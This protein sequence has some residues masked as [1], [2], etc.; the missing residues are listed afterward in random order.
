MPKLTKA[1]REALRAA[2]TETTGPTADYHPGIV[3]EFTDA[4]GE[5]MVEL[6]DGNIEPAT[7]WV[8]DESTDYPTDAWSSESIQRETVEEALENDRC[9]ICGSVD[10]FREDHPADEPE[11]YVPPRISLP[12]IDRS[13]KPVRH[14]TG[15]K[16]ALYVSGFC[17]EEHRLQSGQLT[18]A[19]PEE[20]ANRLHG[21]CPGGT[22][23][24]AGVI[25]I[26]GCPG[27]DGEN[28]C[29]ICRTVNDPESFDSERR[30]CLDVEACED[31]LN[32]RAAQAA[33]TPLARMIREVKEV[34][35]QARRE[36]SVP[37][38][39]RSDS[40][41]GTMPARR[42]SAKPD[43][44]PRPCQCGCALLT[45]GGLFRPGHDAKLK[46]A[47]KRAA[48]DAL[49][50]LEEAEHAMTELAA[51]GWPTPIAPAAQPI[52]EFL[53]SEEM[54][55]DYIAV[56]VAGRYEAAEAPSE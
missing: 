16:E 54:K 4:D 52:A 34:S 6:A 30:I 27:H 53:A 37:R 21:Q 22:A 7:D 20:A 24:G 14:L 33:Q 25:T 42:Q 48:A 13:A 8:Q 1:A 38:S 18:G 35:R 19:S 45:G 32:E 31:A 9:G 56:R 10:H 2:E 47:L 43:R 39:N 40:P 55:Q 5:Q 3:D 51:R 29:L 49:G 12:K 46:G 41:L 28:R 36:S 44:Q 50:D 17:E 23:N 26:C 11:E 15:S